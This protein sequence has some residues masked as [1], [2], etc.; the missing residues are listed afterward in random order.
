MENLALLLLSNF[1]EET[2]NRLLAEHCRKELLPVVETFDEARTD[3]D[4]L[5]QRLRRFRS[6]KGVHNV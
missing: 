4:T 1:D 6:F 2:S 3:L 5:N